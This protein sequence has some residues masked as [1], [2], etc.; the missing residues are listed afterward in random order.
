MTRYH[1]SLHRPA[2]TMV[3][4]RDGAASDYPVQPAAIVLITPLGCP[5]ILYRHMG[6]SHQSPKPIRCTRLVSPQQ[7]ASENQ[8]QERT[9]FQAIYLFN[10]QGHLSNHISIC[11]FQ[12]SLA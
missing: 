4:V 6:R 1:G 2:L 3:H 11:T 10:V 7:S 9:A 8:M 5:V 12:A